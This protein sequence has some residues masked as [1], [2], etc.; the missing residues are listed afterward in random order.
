M[1]KRVFFFYFL[2]SNIELEPSL[3]ALDDV[4][5]KLFKLLK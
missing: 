3:N 2:C 5:D 1:F 4:R